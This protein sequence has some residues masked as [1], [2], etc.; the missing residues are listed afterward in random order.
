VG[1]RARQGG[2]LTQTLSLTVAGL[3]MQVRDREALIGLAVAPMLFILAFRLFDLPLTGLPPGTDYFDFVVPGLL[4]MGL[5]QMLMVGMAGSIARYREMQILKRMQV[6]PVRPSAFIAGQVTSRL[7]LAAVKLGLML[8][9]GVALGASVA[10]SWVLML[11][12]ATAGNLV[13]LTLAFVVAGRVETVEGANNLAGLATIPLMFLSG[14]FFPIETMP[15]AFQT[16][17]RYL[18]ITPVI[19]ALRAIALEG[20]GIADLGRELAIIGAWMVGGFVFARLA[21]RFGER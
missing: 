17:V 15:E 16:V 7:L 12:I 8:A 18:P 11:A 6:T 5:M 9:L 19:D 10:G 14:M 3:R 21:F 13:F 20:A 2:N 1:G 4:A